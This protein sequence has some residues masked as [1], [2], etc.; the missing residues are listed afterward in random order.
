MRIRQITLLD[1]N[2]F[3]LAGSLGLLS[4]C[5]NPFIYASR[6]EVFRRSLKQMFSKNAVAAGNAGWITS[7]TRPPPAFIVR[8]QTTIVVRCGRRHCYTL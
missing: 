5:V 1:I 8:H 3:A 2:A 7:I 6:Y 4:F